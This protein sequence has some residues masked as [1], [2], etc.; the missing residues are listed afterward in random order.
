MIKGPGFDIVSPSDPAGETLRRLASR[1]I[2]RAFR[3]VY[4]WALRIP[5]LAISG[6]SDCRRLCAWIIRP[7]CEARPV[8]ARSIVLDRA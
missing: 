6:K 5:R 8:L 3:R 1:S 4:R 2:C 7:N